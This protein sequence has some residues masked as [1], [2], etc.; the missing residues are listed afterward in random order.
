MRTKK[1]VLL[2]LI[3]SLVTGFLGSVL[4]TVTLLAYYSAESGHFT[5]GDAGILPALGWGVCVAGALACALLCFVHREGLSNYEKRNGKLYTAAST[6]L[7]CAMLTVIFESFS[8]FAK[9]DPSARSVNMI[10]AVGALISCI[11]VFMNT[12][13]P[14]KGIDP[15]R[16]GVSVIPA[17]FVVLPGYRLYF[18]PNLVMNCPNKNVYIIASCLAAA[19]IIYECRFNTEL[20]NTAVYAM[21]CCGTLIFGMF[22][23]IPNLIYCA[24]HGGASVINSLASDLLITCLAVFAAAQLLSVHR[25]KTNIRTEEKQ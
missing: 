12:F 19:M 18:D 8:A 25:S 14:I 9:G 24:L 23:G 15:I 22:C 2:C 20:R 5:K 10:I 1:T 11:T 13:L 17:I 3:I 16:A 7:V 6:V 4:R 21:A